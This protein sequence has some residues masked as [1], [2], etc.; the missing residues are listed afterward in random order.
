ME[1][2]TIEGKKSLPGPAFT[3]MCGSAPGITLVRFV[4]CPRCR[5][6]TTLAPGENLFDGVDT[7]VRYD[8]APVRVSI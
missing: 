8:R 4:P 3:N 2:M 5:K 7:G 6:F 1:I